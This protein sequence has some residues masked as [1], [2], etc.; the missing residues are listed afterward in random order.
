MRSLSTLG[1][2]LALAAPQ[3][4]A[5]TVRFLVTE[6]P[7]SAFHRDGYVLPLSDDEAIAHA[8]ALVAQGPAAGA[9]IAFARIVAGGD[10]VNRNLLAPG[11]PAWSWHVTEFLGFADLGAEIFDGWPGFVIA[12]TSSFYVFAKHVKLWERSEGRRPAAP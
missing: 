10:G 1:L 7:G 5:E 3:A 4:H 9:T 8:R 6:W 11:A 12:A 2:V